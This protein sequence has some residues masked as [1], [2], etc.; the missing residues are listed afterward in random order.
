MTA[1]RWISQRSKVSLAL[2][3][4]LVKSPGASLPTDEAYPHGITPPMRNVRQEVFA[5]QEPVDPVYLKQVSDQML[6][7]CEV[8]NPAGPTCHGTLK[9]VSVPRLARRSL[10]HLA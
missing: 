7:I 8:S 9:H 3:I 1:D 2:Q 10:Q 6:Q 5:A 4:L